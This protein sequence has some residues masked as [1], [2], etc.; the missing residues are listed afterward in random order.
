MHD[1][2]HFPNIITEQ[3]RKNNSQCD[4]TL[5]Q[6]KRMKQTMSTNRERQ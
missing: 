6:P 5:N 2:G 1:E 3:K 4:K